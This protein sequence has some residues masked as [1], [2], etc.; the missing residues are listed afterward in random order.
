MLRL[1]DRPP[2]HKVELVVFPKWYGVLHIRLFRIRS[3]HLTGYF[4]L[5]VWRTV[6]LLVDSLASATG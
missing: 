5:H 4:M 3:A 6:S 2:R 1:A